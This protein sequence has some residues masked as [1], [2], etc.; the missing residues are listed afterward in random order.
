V[1]LA[2][3]L[4]GGFLAGWFD[5]VTMVTGGVLVGLGALTFALGFGL[6]V[7]ILWFNRPRFLVPPHLRGEPGTV[8]ESWRHR[9]ELRAALREAAR[10][11]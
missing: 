3:C 7:T 6:H 11:P 9:G 5:G 10:R 8:I 1:G 4:T 2:L